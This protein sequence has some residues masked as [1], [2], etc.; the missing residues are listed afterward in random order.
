MRV[1]LLVPLLAVMT[2]YWRAWLA[3]AVPVGIVLLWLRPLVDETVSHDPSAG[4]RARGLAHYGSQLV[5]SGDHHFRLA[6]ENFGRS[7]SVAVATLFLLPVIGLALRRRWAAFTLGGTLIVLLL[8]LVPWLFVHLSDAVSLSQSRRLVG[9]IPFPFA[10]AGIAALVAR[11]TVAVPVALVAGVVLQHFWPGDF[12]YG[13]RHGGPG[14]AAWIALF[15]GAASLVVFLALRRPP[16]REQ[17]TLGL[18]AACA[19]VLP[20]FVHGVAHWSPEPKSDPLALSPRLVHNLRTKV[21]RG[22]IVLAPLEVSYRVAASAPVYIVAAPVAHVANTRANDPYG[23][24]RAVR[25]WVL[26]DDP[27]IAERYG[28]TWAIRGG[29]LYRLAR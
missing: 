13:L 6:A 14:V 17:H 2:W 27:R 20:V 1:F 7:G 18:A 12:A 9:F 4:E 25:H 22:A 11:R 21:P 8:T 15:G 3:A 28:A 5:V 23:R 26:T 10:F 24:A 29:R 16:L 19:F